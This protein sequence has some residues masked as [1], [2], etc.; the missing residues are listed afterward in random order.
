MNIGSDFTLKIILDDAEAAHMQSR[1]AEIEIM[2]EVLSHQAAV[3]SI[4][5]ANE[6]VYAAWRKA[7]KD[8]RWY[9]RV[10]SGDQSA[11][12]AYC[13][14]NVDTSD[15]LMWA[16]FGPENTDHHLL[17][18]IMWS[19]LRQDEAMQL[20]QRLEKATR[21]IGSAWKSQRKQV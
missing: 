3:P 14:E 7:S 8:Y 15:K 11:V 10:L 5:L 9:I 2:R 12:R 19:I 4:S 20:A 13:D 1:F 17:L 21:T 16:D 18:H 6:E